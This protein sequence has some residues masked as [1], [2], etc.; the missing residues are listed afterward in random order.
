MEIRPLTSEELSA[1]NDTLSLASRI[2]G[3]DKALGFEDVHELYTSFIN[4][5]IDDSGAKIALG[6]AFGQLFTLSGKY[7]WVRISDEYGEET[8]LAPLGKNITVA[9]ISMIQKRLNEKLYV[10]IAELYTE[11]DKII[12]NMI[13]KGE[14]QNR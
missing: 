2:A 14:Y 13:A 10:D 6:I 1:L 8:A 3:K 4:E 7:E 5:N 11:T 9:P 12:Q